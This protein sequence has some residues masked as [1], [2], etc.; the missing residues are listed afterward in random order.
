MAEELKA[1]LARLREERNDWKTR[2]ADASVSH[3]KAETELAASRERERALEARCA[4]MEELLE[5]SAQEMGM[6]DCHHFDP[7][8]V[9]SNEA[10]REERDLCCAIQQALA[11]ARAWSR[12]L[13]G[14]PVV[15][16]E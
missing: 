5:V 1:E 16:E 13:G 2:A 14:I 15:E 7:E 6:R 11:R 9:C 12:R 8:D 10:C 3:L 4:E